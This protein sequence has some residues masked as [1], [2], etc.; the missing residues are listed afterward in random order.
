MGTPKW[1]TKIRHGV[2]LVLAHVATLEVDLKQQPVCQG[3]PKDVIS[4]S[5]LEIELPI[6]FTPKLDPQDRL[7]YQLDIIRL[8][9]SFSRVNFDSPVKSTGA[10]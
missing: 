2:G 5:G 6:P 7:Q 10:Y 4:N 1:E 3:N 8:L 9:E